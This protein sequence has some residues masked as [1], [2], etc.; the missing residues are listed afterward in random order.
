MSSVDANKAQTFFQYGNEAALKSNFDYAI[1]M[2]QRACKLAPDNLLYRQALR[3]TERKKFQNDPAKVGRLDLARLQPLRM[4]LRGAKS[5]QN[6]ANVLEI[7]EEAFVLH[8]WDITT[9][10]DAAEAAEQLGHSMLAQWLLES[11]H[12]Q[13]S[14]AEFFRHLAHV[15]ELNQEWQKAIQSWER[16]KKIDPT[17]ELASRMINPLSASSTIQRAGLGDAIDKRAAAP[18]AAEKAAEL[19]EMKK[20][21]L[22]PEQQ[23]VQDIKEDPTRISPYLELAE[24]YTERNQLEEAEKILSRG[25]KTNP[26]SPDL[27][28]A[29]AEVQISRLQHAVDVLDQEVPREARRPH[30]QGQARPVHHDARRIRGK[31]IPPPGRAASRGLEPPLPARPEAGPRR[32]ARRGDR[33]VPAGPVGSGAEGRGAPPGGPELRGQGG[34]EAGR[35]ELTRRR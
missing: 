17:D 27:R 15:Y 29:H 1:E 10:R 24:H 35:A 12:A 8:P 18:S 22:T 19:E 2:Y 34:A 13:A 26:E 5:K 14:D 16:V 31:G 32:Q 7:C 3:G 23:W 25:I 20:P 33:R 9:A 21:K 11:V 28:D 6:W 30:A 4:K